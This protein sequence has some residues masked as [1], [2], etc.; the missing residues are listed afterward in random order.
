[1]AQLQAPWTEEQVEALNHNQ[2]SGVMHEYT[3][4]HHHRKYE[5]RVLVATKDGW[6]CP[7]RSCDYRQNWAHDFSTEKLVPYFP[8][9]TKPEEEK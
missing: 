9:D 4:P 5:D 6:I 8:W 7:Q 3:C 1:M 2:H